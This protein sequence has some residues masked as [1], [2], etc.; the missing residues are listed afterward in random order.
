VRDKITKEPLAPYNGT[1]PEM[2]RLNAY[3]KSR[4][5]Y[6]YGRFNVFIVVPPLIIKREEL[7]YGL[8]IIEEALAEVDKMLAA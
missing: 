7:E 2:A 1:S 4:Y 5:L 8:D 6:T 3:L